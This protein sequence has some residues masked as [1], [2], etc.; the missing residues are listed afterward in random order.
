MPWSANDSTRFTKKANTPAKKD[1]WAKVANDALRRGLSEGAAV[2]EA[3]AAVAGVKK[4]K[5]KAT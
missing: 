2:R 3:N 1:L 4:K 5:R